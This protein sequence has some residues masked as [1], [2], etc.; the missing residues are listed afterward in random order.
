MKREVTTLDC[1][2]CTPGSGGTVRT[3]VFGLDGTRYESEMCPE[4]EQ[5]LRDAMAAV[6]ERARRLPA[7]S[8]KPR[9]QHKRNRDA[10]IRARAV[11]AGESVNPRGR[12]PQH[13]KDRYSAA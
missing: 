1:D 13:I 5:K 4:H 3:V 6:I 7:V 12:L 9:P 2:H 11:A 10:A 8:S